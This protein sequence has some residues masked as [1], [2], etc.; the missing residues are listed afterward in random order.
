M[1]LVTALAC[2]CAFGQAAE[3]DGPEDNPA[4]LPTERQSKEALSLADGEQQADLNRNGIP[5][6]LRVSGSD[7][8]MRL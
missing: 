4:P 3:P 8:E 6:T 2:L 5:E 1:V 7:E